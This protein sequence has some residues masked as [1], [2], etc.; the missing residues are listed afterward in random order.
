LEISSHVYRV[1]TLLPICLLS[2]KMHTDVSPWRDT[3]DEPHILKGAPCTAFG[4]SD[5]VS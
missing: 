3:P 2:G 1:E 4:I 5:G